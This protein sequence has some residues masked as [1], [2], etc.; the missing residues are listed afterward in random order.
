MTKLMR[1]V[2]ALVAAA[3]VVIGVGVVGQVVNEDQQGSSATVVLS[4]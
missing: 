2:L 3:A 4:N 1:E